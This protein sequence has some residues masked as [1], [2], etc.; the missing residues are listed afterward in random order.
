MIAQKNITK[1]AAVIMAVAVCLCLAAMVF[2]ETIKD[3][4]GGPG[5]TMEYESRLFDTKEIISINI[6]MDEADWEEMLAN[7]VSE[8][9]YQCDVEINGQMFSRV[10][11]RP[12]GHTSLTSIA[13]DPDT[14]RY[15]FKM[16]FDQYVDGQT[17]YGLDKL[18][19]NNNYADATSMKEALIYDMYKYLGTDA[20][21]YNYAKISVNGK[22]WG[23]YLALEAVEDSFMLRNYGTE[24]GKLYK[25]E[26]MNMGKMGGGNLGGK[27]FKN[28]EPPQDF[29]TSQIAGIQNQK[30]GGFSMG[31][32]GANLNYIDKDTDSYSTI[33]EGEV[34]NTT[35][36]DH[37]RVVKAL[38]NISESTDIE[39]YMD[40]DNL[41]K[42]MAVHV[43]SVNEDS[44]LG[45]MAHNYYLYESDGQLNILP[46]DYNLALGGMDRMG[47]RNG[48]NSA[49]STVN[50]AIDYAF[51]GTEFFDI[52][53]EVEEYKAKYYS[54][55]QQLTEEYI[56]GGGFEE[57]YNRT[58][59][60]IDSLI[61]SDPTSF[62][63]YEEYKEAADTLYKLV[64]LRG[65][66]INNQIEGT[67]PSTQKE[68]MDSDSLI[69]ASHLDLSV[70]GSMSMDD[71]MRN[72]NDGDDTPQLDERELPEDFDKSKVEN[73]IPKDGQFPPGDGMGNKSNISFDTGG[74]GK[75][76]AGNL[77]L[78]G[79][80]SIVLIA[81]IVFAK[82]YRRRYKKL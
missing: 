50:D 43:F 57:F 48:G 60:L 49:T 77:I 78:Y 66:S 30:R 20:S 62:Y 25:P 17:C 71:G 54:Y 24:K 64:E 74:A 81:A 28:M 8:T 1:I 73:R 31:G 46:W 4:L 63:T 56:Y 41:L 23:V 21:L 79:I 6:V 14:D 15:S 33:W 32:N 53:M 7:A 2:E 5:I 76:V 59:S 40:V 11:I 51:S 38:K 55:M 70:M 16:E 47:G 82:L 3:A 75:T 27:D 69:D 72:W 29:E 34:T 80:C 37:K 9:Y 61:E 45:N 35:N 18:V 42:Y 22:Y 13:N 44:L 67:I 26:S 58:R 65:Q 12:K 36:S 39:K 68:Q 19:L 10:G 52:F